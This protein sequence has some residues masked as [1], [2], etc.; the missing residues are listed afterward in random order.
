MPVWSEPDG[1]RV[2]F[3]SNREGDDAIWWQNANGTGTAERLTK[4]ETGSF[5]VPQSWSRDGKYLSYS[6]VKGSGPAVWILSLADK[7][8]AL[9]SDNASNAAFS[10]DGQWL[11]YQ[12]R[13]TGLGQI[14]VQPF[15]ATGAKFPVVPGGQPFWSHDGR[16]LFYNP[17]PQQ[18]GVVGITTRPTF[19]F[20]E[21]FTFAT[22]GL[23][24]RAPQNS[25]RVWD[26][27][28]DRKRLIGVTDVMESATEGATPQIEV[29]LN[30]FTDLRARVPMRE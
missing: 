28:P 3:R 1:L 14:F 27:A 29:V 4:A 16:E 13:E 20:G 21:P 18:I 30:W 26:I 5:H 17:A 2:A 11:A 7:K 8:S 15:P 19:S 9:F 24:S 12:S 6:V 23:Q 22:A 25:P 10:P